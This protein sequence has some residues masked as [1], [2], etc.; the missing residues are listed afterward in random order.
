MVSEPILEEAFFM[1]DYSVDARNARF[2]SL[3]FANNE[4]RTPVINPK[5]PLYFPNYE[6]VAGQQIVHFEC[7][8]YHYKEHVY[9]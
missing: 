4:K 7:Q 8:L 3:S 5:V 6:H 1:F 9:C 2:S